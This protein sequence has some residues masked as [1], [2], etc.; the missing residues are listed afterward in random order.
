MAAPQLYKGKS[1]QVAQQA[2]GL[3]TGGGKWTRRRRE[4]ITRKRKRKNLAFVKVSAWPFA[5]REAVV[6]ARGRMVRTSSACSPVR[7]SVRV[8]VCAFTRVRLFIT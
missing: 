4:R 2:D 3:Q 5:R 6:L 1:Q 8:Q 7:L